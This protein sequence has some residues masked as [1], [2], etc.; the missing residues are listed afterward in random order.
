MNSSHTLLKTIDTI[1][2]SGLQHLPQIITVKVIAEAG[3]QS[4]FFT[5][6]NTSAHKNISSLFNEESN[7]MP[8]RDHFSILYGV[9]GSYPAVFLEVKESQLTLFITQL[10]RISIEADYIA[11][12]DQFAIRRSSAKFWAYSDELTEWYKAHN[13]VEAGLLDYN[14]FENR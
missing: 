2:G 14:R 6:F 3:N 4:E 1:Q 7:R 9:V 5:L 8:E 12:L 10:R 13:P 11:L